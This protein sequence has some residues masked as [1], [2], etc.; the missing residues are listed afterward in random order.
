MRSGHC[1]QE[2]T[3]EKGAAP[4]DPAGPSIF[5]ANVAGPCEEGVSDI[6]TFA[7]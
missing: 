1:H 2:G 4:E 5:E 3:E 6:C 7:G